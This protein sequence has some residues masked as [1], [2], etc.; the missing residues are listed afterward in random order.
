M[1][2]DYVDKER[3]H[4]YFEKTTYL[5]CNIILKPRWLKNK[6][7]HKANVAEYVGI[8]THAPYL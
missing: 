1:F 3:N 8:R 4:V 7:W 6:I 5:K 2:L